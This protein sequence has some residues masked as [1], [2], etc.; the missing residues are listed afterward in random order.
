MKQEHK[1]DIFISYRRDGGEVTA[2][3]LRDSLTELGYRVFFDVESLRSGA[4]NT[5]L[6]SVID[7]CNDFILVLSPNAL[8]RCKNQDDWV[9]REIEYALEKKKNVIPI[10]LRNFSFPTDLPLTLK[11][12]PYQS[13]LVANLEYYDAFI[14]KLQEFLT[15]Q[16]PV[17]KRFGDWLRKI[18]L[19]PALLAAALILAGLIFGI[20]WM[21]KY[22][23]TAKQV[24][25]TSGIVSN[26]S[27]NLTCMDILAGAQANMLEAAQDC[28][29]TGEEDI[30]AN[31]FAVCYQTFTSTDLSLAQPGADLL[32]QMQRSPFSPDDLQAMHSLLLT[33]RDDCLTT[34]S[35]M[36]YI[37]SE[38]CML[39]ASEKMETVKLYR[40]NLEETVKWFAY[41]ANESLLPV[42]REK[43]LEVFWKETLPYLKE[44]PLQAKDWS[45]DKD[46]LVEAGNKCYENIQ[47]IGAEL[48]G[49]LGESTMALRQQQAEV[50]KQL[51]DAGYTKERAEKIVTYM[52]RDWE[53]ELTESYIRK[54]YSET[55]AASLAK[56]EAQ[57]KKWE[58]DV[59]LSF[60]P[61][62]TD[63]MNTVWEKMTYLLSL[64][65]Y[66]EAEE[67][68]GLYQSQM[69]NS[70]RYMPALIL[71]LQMLQ[72]GQLDHGIMVMEYYE[73]DGINEQ[74][75]IGDI[76][77]ELDG[78]P[79]T[80]FADYTAKKEALTKDT[81]TV[82]LLRLEDNYEIQVLEITLDVDSPR[83][84]LNDLIA[85]PKA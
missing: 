53:A 5:K 21:Q 4:F 41:C 11:D 7:E 34:L 15:T 85:A 78:Q 75:M 60:S 72:K 16:K 45:R 10:L 79:V 76:I 28:L 70:D 20:S 54:G 66:E 59:I 58:Q 49:I 36:E 40:A 65:F 68:I 52:S 43:H 47:E 1:Y 55:E 63:D 61:R 73:E 14:E 84:W 57:Q 2:R 3:I 62:L 8:D 44:I 46:A 26:I 19:V 35:Y 23:R 77:Y 18:K 17:R 6:Y 83:V 31:R 71:F 80:S 22:P 42:T 32:A 39:S 38:E 30:C 69:T 81:Y 12:L 82:K 24:N 64:G 56:E 13:G 74:L 25:L 50:R 48:K 29:L 67:C 51:T 9:R 27:Y 33:F 37:V